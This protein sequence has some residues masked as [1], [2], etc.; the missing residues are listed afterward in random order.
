M[1]DT[2]TTDLEGVDH[3]IAIDDGM[4]TLHI[5]TSS[6]GSLYAKIVSNSP[7]GSG[8]DVGTDEGAARALYDF[9]GESLRRYGLLE[10]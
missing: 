3:A 6:D 8:H 2:I 1:D 4:D 10:A 9:L 7:G 5:E